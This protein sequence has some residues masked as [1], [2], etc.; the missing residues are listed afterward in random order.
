MERACR[1]SAWAALG[2]EQI[3]PK[4]ERAAEDGSLACHPTHADGDHPERDLEV[5]CRRYRRQSE[6]VV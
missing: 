1:F 4:N 5:E 2:V 3:G 6:G